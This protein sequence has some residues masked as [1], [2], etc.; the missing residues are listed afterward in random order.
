M[1]GV[2]LA[3]L[4]HVVLANKDSYNILSNREVRSMLIGGAHRH[5]VGLS[6]VRNTKTLLLYVN[7]TVIPALQAVQ[8]YHT[9]FVHD[10]GQTIDYNNKI[11]GVARLRQHRMARNTCPFVSFARSRNMSCVAEFSPYGYLTGAFEDFW[12]KKMAQVEYNRLIDFWK[13]KRD[14]Q[15]VTGRFESYPRGGYSAVLGRNVYNSYFNLDY[16]ANKD[17]LN[18]G[19]RMICVE[20]LIYNVNYNVFNSAKLVLEKTAGGYFDESYTVRKKL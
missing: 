10:P 15:I 3:L 16:I 5:T 7:E 13:F 17:W 19:T 2:Y 12:R 9:Y 4:Y 6:D 18:I 14:G 1:F 11:L 8:W 20:F